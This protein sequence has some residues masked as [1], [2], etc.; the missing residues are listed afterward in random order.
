MRLDQYISNKLALS[1]NRAQF[2]IDE[3]LVK[4]NSKIISKASHQ[5]EENDIVEVIDD[6]K[7]EYVARSAIKIEKFLDLLEDGIIW[8]DC[9]DI[10]ASTWWFTQIL[11]SKWVNS[12]QTIDVGTSQLHEKI[13]SDSR[14]KCTENTDIRNYKTADNYDLIVADLSFIS[15]H[16]ILDKLKELSS[17]NT[18]IILLF[19]PQFEVGRIN[20]KKTWVPK[21]D[22]IVIASLDKFKLAC[23]NIGFR[24]TKIA[25]SEL[26]WEAWNKEFFIYMKLADTWE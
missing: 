23:K 7:I 9:L 16:K 4:V 5:V 10:W 11:L 3:K 1:R 17:K 25:E 26:K 13:K 19:K 22:K 14:V 6:K 18:A 21:D 8:F 24:I 2:L 15:L 20:L 12:V